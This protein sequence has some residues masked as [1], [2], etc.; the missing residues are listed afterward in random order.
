MNSPPECLL[1][2]PPTHPHP[3]PATCRDSVESEHVLPTTHRPRS[4]AP[5]TEPD[6]APRSLNRRLFDDQH[7]GMPPPTAAATVHKQQQRQQQ[8]RAV[9]STGARRPLPPPS[10]V[11]DSMWASLPPLDGPPPSHGA[12][13]RSTPPAHSTALQ[14]AGQMIGQMYPAPA[15][16]APMHALPSAFAA[17]FLQAPPHHYGY[18]APPQRAMHYHPQQQAQQAQ[19]AQY[20][21]QQQQ[22]HHH[23]IHAHHQRLQQQQHAAFN[24]QQHIVTDLGAHNV[25]Y[26]NPSGV[27][28]VDYLNAPT[29]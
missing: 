27:Q 8:Q 24:H 2:H 18:A 21:F 19:Q 6:T 22:H 5:P 20:Y 28:E 29:M 25:D 16:A 14:V 26:L 13:A 15:P 10:S 3:P 9:S 4:S 7:G 23:H 1:R 17:P 12:T 11:S